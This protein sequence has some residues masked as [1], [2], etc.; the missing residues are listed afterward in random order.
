MARNHGFGHLGMF[1][2][3]AT[4][5]LPREARPAQWREASGDSI[6]VAAPLIQDSRGMLSTFGQQSRTLLQ[7]EDRGAHWKQ[8]GP[9]LP[10]DW[11][12]ANM[13]AEA[14]GT[15]WIAGGRYLNQSTFGT[16]S[17]TPGQTAW[18]QRDAGRLD[19]EVLALNSAG[20]IALAGTQ[21]GLWAW[22][23][24]AGN[25]RSLND[26]T[27]QEDIYIM[28]IRVAGDLVFLVN[29]RGDSFRGMRQ[30]TGF[31]WTVSQMR[32]PEALAASGSALFAT[33]L[34]YSFPDGNHRLVRSDDGG[35]TWAARDSGLETGWRVTGL[36]AIG[37]SLFVNVQDPPNGIF[38][39]DDDGGHWAPDTT[40]LPGGTSFRSLV[41]V[42]D[43]LIGAADSGIWILP[44]AAPTALR[45]V[46]EPARNRSGRPA[47]WYPS[48]RGRFPG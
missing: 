6:R 11:Q 14:G 24:G 30:G 43:T 5:A 41:A 47:G 26:T 13:L 44:H 16:Y 25:W 22:D 32:R 27:L 8:V 37:S 45:P 38:R 21:H 7:S 12:P 39:S 18:T 35:L 9:A 1:L 20:G 40:G 48:P 42:G 3:S 10:E 28:G 4:L 23:A 31:R 15:F 2:L 36:T 19:A 46:R 17:W 29:N 34:G 33:C